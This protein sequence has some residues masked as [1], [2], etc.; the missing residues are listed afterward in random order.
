MAAFFCPYGHMLEC[1]FPYGCSQAACSHLEG[2]DFSA[3]EV[4]AL[5]ANAR[6]ANTA[7][8]YDEQGNATAKVSEHE[9]DPPTD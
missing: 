3:E 2:Y 7:Y 5:E 1:H 9:P 4:K 6:V 8:E